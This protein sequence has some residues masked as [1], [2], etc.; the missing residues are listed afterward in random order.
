MMEAE[1]MSHFEK[2]L[3]EEINEMK[4]NLGTRVWWFARCV[5]LPVTSKMD[6]TYY[7]PSHLWKGQKAIKKLLELSIKTWKPLSNGYRNKHLGKCIYLPQSASI[8]PI[9]IIP[10]EKHQFDLLY[11]P[12]DTLYGNKY[13][14]ILAGIDV[15]SSYKVVRP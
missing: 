3:L 15:A 7:Q 10:N 1:N 5:I 6:K 4:E 14:Y 13:K 9:T 8:D 2:R 11:M 12:L